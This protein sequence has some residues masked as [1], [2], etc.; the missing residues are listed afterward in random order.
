MRVHHRHHIGPSFEDTSMDEAFEVE[1]SPF[2]LHRPAVQGEF[3]DVFWSYQF[4]GQRTGQKKPV[5]SLRMTNA[6][7]T[8]SIDD[9]LMSKDAVGDDEIVQQMVQMNHHLPPEAAAGSA[10]AKSVRLTR[11]KN[12]TRNWA[13]NRSVCTLIHPGS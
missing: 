4:R 10:P 3:D 5:R 11:L 7:M 2:F 1:G 9:L 12:S 8:I 13:L 6:D